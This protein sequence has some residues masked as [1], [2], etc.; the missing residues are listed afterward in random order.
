M[1]F[2]KLPKGSILLIEAFD[3]LAIDTANNQFEFGGTTLIA[4]GNKYSSSVAAT[5]LLSYANKTQKRFRRVSEHNRSE[6]NERTL[7][8]EQNQR[9]ANGLLR[10][11]YVADKKQWDVSWTMLPS[12]R[13]ETT[14]GGWGAE[15]IKQFYE[16][17][18][19]K[20]SFRIK[21]NPT[22]F[23]TELIEQ[24]DGVM[25]DDY[26]YTVVFTSCDFT[27]VKRGLQTYWN[28]KLSMEQV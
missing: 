10:K 1:S 26:T 9:M 25:A 20:G 8:I 11:Y 16:S 27:V 6:F 5:N 22:V 14:D 15:D 23:S 2:Q 4:P 3:P 17:S 12:Y 13:N 19:G 24:S 21:I 18:E 7:R 28:V